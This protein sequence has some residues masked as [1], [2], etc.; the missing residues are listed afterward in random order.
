MTDGQHKV[1]DDDDISIPPTPPQP[2]PLFALSTIPFAEVPFSGIIRGKHTGWGTKWRVPQRA[3]PVPLARPV[4]HSRERV[5]RLPIRTPQREIER[6]ARPAVLLK[7]MGPFG[8]AYQ[9]AAG[10]RGMCPCRKQHQCRTRACK[11]LGFVGRRLWST[12]ERPQCT[13]EA[14]DP[15]SDRRLDKAT[16]PGHLRPSRGA[17]LLRAP[18]ST[19]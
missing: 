12:A 11:P 4:R 5:L 13:N 8:A 7:R 17:S 1:A 14:P 18:P 16:S 3:S 15:P 10:F 9:V 2:V 6:K 19:R